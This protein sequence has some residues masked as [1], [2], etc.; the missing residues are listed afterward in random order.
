[1][2]NFLNNL[3]DS[4]DTG[5][6]NSEAAKKILEINKLVE[7]KEGI[8]SSKFIEKYIDG[9]RAVAVDE[10]FAIE[11]NKLAETKYEEELKN[12]ETLKILA[13]IENIEEKILK[14]LEN[15]NSIF[16]EVKSTLD[17]IGIDKLSPTELLL[18]N[19][20]KQDIDVNLL[21]LKVNP[22]NK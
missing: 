5:E 8:S 11:A 12:S 4:L 10:S 20:V 21:M 2:N 22:L 15:L 18:Y 1:M 19:K 14:E 9:N 17:E 7:E 16:N 6:F 3:K 13:E